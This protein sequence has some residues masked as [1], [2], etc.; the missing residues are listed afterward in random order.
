MPKKLRKP[1]T[2]EKGPAI[3]EGMQFFGNKKVQK[4]M[5]EAFKNTPAPRGV[6]KGMWFIHFGDLPKG[7]KATCSDC[8]DFKMSVCEGGGDPYDCFSEETVK[9]KREMQASL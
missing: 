8:A 9:W 4:A 5:K 2:K 3:E 7:K 6:N 1:K